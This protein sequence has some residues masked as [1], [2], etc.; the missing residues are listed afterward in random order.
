M[1]S[2]NCELVTADGGFD[3][4]IDFNKQ[5]QLSY[6]LIFCEIV[7]ALSVQ[8][9]GGSFVCKFFDTYSLLTIKFLWLLN[10]CY[11]S[12]IFTKPLT[13]RSANSEKYIIAYQ[14]RGIDEYYLQQLYLMVEK[15]N[16]VEPNSYVTDIFN[17]P[18]PKDYLNIIRYYNNYMILGQ[19]YNIIKTLHLIKSNTSELKS[20]SLI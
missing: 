19:T 4:S 1:G 9:I 13:S 18:I 2:N 16:H 12:V 6:Q 14:F 8:K 11:K 3:F 20:S 5:E 10:I 15:W 17:Y 7:S